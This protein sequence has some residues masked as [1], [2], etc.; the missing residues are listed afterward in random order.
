MWDC[1]YDDDQNEEGDHNVGH[2]GVQGPVDPGHQYKNSNAIFLCNCFCVWTFSVH[3]VGNGN[4]KHVLIVKLY[5]LNNSYESFFRN[6]FLD[7]LIL[8]VFHLHSLQIVKSRI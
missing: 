1:A 5:I 8:I 6:V 2:D 7:N 3:V 4:I